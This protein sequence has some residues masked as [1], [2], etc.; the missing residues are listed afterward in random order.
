[1]TWRRERVGTEARSALDAGEA[2]RADHQSRVVYSMEERHASAA[3]QHAAVSHSAGPA[4]LLAASRATGG[5]RLGLAARIAV[6]HLL[7]RGL[8]MTDE[9]HRIEHGGRLA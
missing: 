1:M 4:S 2:G 5:H 7:E 9:A 3:S 8:Q 6:P